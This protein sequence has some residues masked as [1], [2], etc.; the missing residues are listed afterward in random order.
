MK[1]YARTLECFRICMGTQGQLLPSLARPWALFMILAATLAAIAGAVRLDGAR[2]DGHAADTYRPK[3][4]PPEVVQPFLKD[5]DPG[6]DTFPDERTAVELEARLREL[7]TSLR[8][9][10]ARP[11]AG[12]RKKTWPP[13]ASARGGRDVVASISCTEPARCLKPCEGRRASICEQSVNNYLP[14]VR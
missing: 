2:A 14:N 10:P 4:A 6:N 7:G 12:P 11:A 8:A 5:L 13:A 1:S 3:L 9:G